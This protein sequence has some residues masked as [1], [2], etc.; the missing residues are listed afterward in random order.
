MEIL[1][2]LEKTYKVATVVPEWLDSEI[3][4]HKRPRIYCNNG[5]SISVQASKDHYCEPQENIQDGKYS[6]VELGMPSKEIPELDEYKEIKE[7]RQTRSV[8]PYVPI[9]LIEQII[10]Q[11]GGIDNEKTYINNKIK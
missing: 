7:K 10:Q 2:F 8:F 11:N 1:E 4:I 5:F 9:E 3:F 6:Q